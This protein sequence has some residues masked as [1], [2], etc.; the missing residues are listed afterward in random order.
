MTARSTQKL[1]EIIFQKLSTDN[2]LKTLLGGIHKIKHA[3]PLGISEY[4]CVVYDLIGDSDEPY[5]PDVP[6][7]IAKTRVLVQVF[8]SDKATKQSDDIEDRVYELLHGLKFAN[9][10]YIIYSCERVTR[11]PFFDPG[12][13]VWRIESRY[14]VVNGAL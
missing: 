2:T 4:P 11:F 8:S 1:K 14:D 13:S 3:N 7:G 6:T 9:S 10:D 5:S 12:P